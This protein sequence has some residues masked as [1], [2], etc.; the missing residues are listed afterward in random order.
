MM[1][2]SQIKRSRRS[3]LARELNLKNKKL[4]IKIHKKKHPMQSKI[5]GKCSRC[6]GQTQVVVMASMGLMLIQKVIKKKISKKRWASR[7]IVIRNQAAKES[8]INRKVQIRKIIIQRIRRMRLIIRRYLAQIRLMKLHKM[9]KTKE[10]CLRFQGQM[11]A[12]VT[13]NMDLTLIQQLL[14]VMMSQS[15]KQFNQIKRRKKWTKVETIM[16]K[17]LIRTNSKPTTVHQVVHLTVRFKCLQTRNQTTIV[18]LSYPRLLKQARSRQKHSSHQ[19]SNLM[20]EARSPKI[21]PSTSSWQQPKTRSQMRNCHLKNNSQSS[22][23]R[24]FP[25][26]N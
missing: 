19:V 13:V 17:L 26:L 3:Q 14:L 23:Q 7:K 1:K 15:L 24:K 22:N 2:K 25:V 20:T 9:P 12:A 16:V 21:H 5:K 18:H 10:K 8:W 4:P 11:R 6:Q